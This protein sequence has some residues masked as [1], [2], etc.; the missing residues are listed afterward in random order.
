MSKASKKA[1]ARMNAEHRARQ[2]TITPVTATQKA[3]QSAKVPVPAAK[4]DPE[5]PKSKARSS[6]DK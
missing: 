4:P 2:P 3:K 1:R 5:M 6:R